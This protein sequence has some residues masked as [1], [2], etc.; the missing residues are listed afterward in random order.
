MGHK[1]KEREEVYAILRFDAFHAS[2]ATRPEDTVTVKE[3]VRSI[4]TAEAEVNR[5]NEVNGDENVRYW[6]Q[7]TRLFP[8][9]RSA[10]ASSN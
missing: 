4:E 10:G 6:W 5:L 9:D 2:A 7:Q 8:E 1:Y 3:V